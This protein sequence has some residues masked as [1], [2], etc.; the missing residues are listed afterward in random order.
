[1]YINTI[2]SFKES[3]VIKKSQPINDIID[4]HFGTRS[5]ICDELMIAPGPY[6]E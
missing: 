5:F 4:F 3:L 6:L 1:M 2:A